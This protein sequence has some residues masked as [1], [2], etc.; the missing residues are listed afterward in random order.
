[1]RAETGRA[2]QRAARSR[3]RV[4]HI[5][6]RALVSHVRRSTIAGGADRRNERIHAALAQGRQ[7]RDDRRERSAHLRRRLARVARSIER[8]DLSG[9]RA[10][11]K[12]KRHHVRRSTELSPLLAR[13]V[14]AVLERG[15]VFAELSKVILVSFIPSEARDQWSKLRRS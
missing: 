12:R 9:E 3:S 7:H 10:V 14:A 2:L 5:D 15:V 6:E 4:P 8:C 11:R 13:N 1:R